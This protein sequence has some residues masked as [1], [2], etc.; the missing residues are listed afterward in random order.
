METNIDSI[1]IATSVNSVTDGAYQQAKVKGV[2]ESI[3]SGLMLLIPG[4][5]VEAE[6]FSDDNRAD[7][8]AGYARRWDE[9]NPTRYFMAVD[10]N[11]VEKPEA[12]VMKAKAEKFTLDVHTAFAY[13]QQAFGALKNEE[14]AKHA[15]IKDVR[16]RFNKY[17]SNC[18]NDL[19][20]EASRIHKARNNIAG[21]KNPVAAFYDWLMVGDKCQLT[22][23]RQR[24]VNAQSRGDETVDLK[25]LDAALVAFKAKMK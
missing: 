2:T 22:M 1:T 4:L 14:P 18:L 5:G 6:P 23:I 7:L 16:D 11:W 9:I 24:A 17:V 3:V 15:L 10:G 20:R 21:T 8:R 12:E 13:S 25:K 19:K